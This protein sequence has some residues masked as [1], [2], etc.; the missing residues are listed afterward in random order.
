MEFEAKI[1]K[2]GSVMMRFT[3][4]KDSFGLLILVESC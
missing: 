2:Q 3:Y 4:L 1:F